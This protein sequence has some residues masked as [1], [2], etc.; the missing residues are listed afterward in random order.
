MTSEPVARRQAR[1]VVTVVLSLACMTAQATS[2]VI[3]IDP[4]EPANTGFT[5][6]TP[7]TALPDNPG[8]TLGAQ[9]LYVFQTAANQWGN[10]I[11][12]A[13][14]IRVLAKMVGLTCNGTTATLGSAGPHTAF[15]NFPSAPKGNTFYA[16]AEANALAGSDQDPAADD[17]DA[18]FNVTLD[19]G[20]CLNGTT[21]WYYGTNPANPVPSGT[22][23]LMPVIFHE[24]G[25][26]LGFIS[27]TNPA[28]GA[29]PAGIPD[30][31][32]YYQYDLQTGSTWAGMS[33]A[34]RAASALNDPNLIWAGKA[35]NAQ[36][37][38]FMKPTPQQVLLTAPTR[39]AAPYP[40]GAAQFGPAL[41]SAGIAGN[42]VLAMNGSATDGCTAITSS[43]SGKLA[44]IDR[45]TCSFTIKVKNAQNA[46][47][48]AALIANNAPGLF[49]MT[50]SD[51]SITIASLLVTQELGSLIKTAL[52]SGTVSATLSTGNQAAATKQGCVRQYAPPV[53]EQGSSVSHF[54]SD[55]YPGLLMGPVLNETIF[56]HVD[57]TLPL[58]KDI[59]WSTNID[60]LLFYDGFDGN[61]CAVVQP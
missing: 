29:L 46:G 48:A 47:A 60:D 18:S 54:H 12:S 16:V 27:L 22:V 45:G 20:T 40:A 32:A 3:D 7:R 17:I 19:S 53:L 51:P 39:L 42:V 21:G 2:V 1:R 5:D 15:A 13:V 56:N 38:A 24:L 43:V 6:P 30:I 34:Q 9:R 58:F 36:A 31:W 4:T 61:P 33:D 57:L 23:P 44:L 25:H 55:A 59:G 52:G 49:T 50:G 41:T 11:N 10:L 37:P 28:T 8:T 35:T 26:G 14:T